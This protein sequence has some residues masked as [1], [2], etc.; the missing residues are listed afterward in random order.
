MSLNKLITKKDPGLPNSKFLLALLM[1]TV[2][3]SILRN[4]ESEVQKCRE[5]LVDSLKHSLV[6]RFFSLKS[7]QLS[8]SAASDSLGPHG[9]QHARLSRPSPALGARFLKVCN[10]Q[11]SE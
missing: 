6:Q 7:V 1:N 4:K 3:G 8:H 2:I 10:R 11:H 9:L 5:S